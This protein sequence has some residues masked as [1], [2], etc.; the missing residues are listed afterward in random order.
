MVQKVHAVVRQTCTGASCDS[1][2]GRAV[3]MTQ[4]RLQQHR[5][6]VGTSFQRCYLNGAHSSDAASHTGSDARATAG[7]LLDA[8]EGVT[9]PS[10]C[11]LL[12]LFAAAQAYCEHDCYSCAT[13]TELTLGRPAS[14]RTR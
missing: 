5:H 14:A 3:R 8:L 6:V 10:R 7:P 13:S 12:A 2:A 9:T 1:S 4:S 11:I